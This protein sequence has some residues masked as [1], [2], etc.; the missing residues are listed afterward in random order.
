MEHLDGDAIYKASKKVD[1]VAGP[2]SADC[3]MWQWLCPIRNKKKPAELTGD[4]QN[5]PE[6]EL[7]AS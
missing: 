1:G 3:N 5:C 2:S 6:V 7:C 4:C